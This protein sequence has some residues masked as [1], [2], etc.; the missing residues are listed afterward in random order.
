MTNSN[1]LPPA[2]GNAG[3]GRAIRLRGFSPIAP[4][5]RLRLPANEQRALLYWAGTYDFF[6]PA[7][8]RRLVRRLLVDQLEVLQRWID[9]G[10][11]DQTP[12]VRRLQQ[13]I[14]EIR[15]GYDM[16]HVRLSLADR[17][18][19]ARDSV[20]AK[21]RRLFD[22]VLA[23]QDAAEVE[24]IKKDLARSER[25]LAARTERRESRRP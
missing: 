25:L 9:D 3:L 13:D 16:W 14:R 8:Q 15:R 10:F 2:N 20:E 7:D 12:V 23:E 19:V 1:H 17:A 11:D 21:R 18:R 5:V 6:A 4:P 22:A 24:A